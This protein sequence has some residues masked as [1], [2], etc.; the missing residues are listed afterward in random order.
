MPTIVAMASYVFC[1][2]C[3]ERHESYEK[4]LRYLTGLVTDERYDTRH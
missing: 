3:D 2:V 4:A 1:R